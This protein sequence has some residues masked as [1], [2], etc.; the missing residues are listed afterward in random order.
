MLPDA[1]DILHNLS[2]D[3]MDV[4]HLWDTLSS[5]NSHLKKDE[6]LEALKSATVD[7]GYPKVKLQR[8]FLVLTS[9][10]HMK[11][12]LPVRPACVSLMLG[13]CFTHL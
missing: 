3:K 5:S 12:A 4:S 8:L 13:V 10:T 6:F 1:V 7:G 9:L 2:K 11:R